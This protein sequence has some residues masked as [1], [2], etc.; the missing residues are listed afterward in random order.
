MSL[1][2]IVAFLCIVILGLAVCAVWFMRIYYDDA[3]LYFP[4][5][6]SSMCILAIAMASIIK[7]S[8]LIW[9]IKIM[10]FII[11]TMMAVMCVFE[12]IKIKNKPFDIET[13]ADCEEIVQEKRGV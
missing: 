12:A 1:I 9:I 8:E 5:V 10:T 3:R 7:G 2:D 11:P 13:G 4:A 6:R